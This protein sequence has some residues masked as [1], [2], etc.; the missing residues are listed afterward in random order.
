MVKAYSAYSVFKKRGPVRFHNFFKSPNIMKLSLLGMFLCLKR[1]LTL[2]YIILTLLE[3][4]G[5][6]V[7]SRHKIKQVVLFAGLE[8]NPLQNSVLSKCISCQL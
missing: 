8:V 6:M 3:N 2:V 4:G 5:F 1:R 7:K